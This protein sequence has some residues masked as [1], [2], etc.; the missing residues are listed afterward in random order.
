MGLDKQNVAWEP[1]NAACRDHVVAYHVQAQY[2]WLHKCRHQTKD[3]F[4]DNQLSKLDNLKGG[5]A[6]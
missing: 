2:S 1:G 4:I 5:V 3:H 6:G